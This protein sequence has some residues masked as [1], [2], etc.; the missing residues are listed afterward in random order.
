MKIG[1]IIPS[2]GG[3]EDFGPL[4]DSIDKNLKYLKKEIRYLQ[5]F[6]IF[7]LNG[8]YQ[9]PKKYLQMIG[10]KGFKIKT[11]IS[12]KPGKINAIKEAAKGNTADYLFLLDDDIVFNESLFY[13]A[14]LEFKKHPNLKLVSTQPKTVD[15]W[16]TNPFRKFIYDIIN[17]RSL[18]S[19][20]KGKDPF[21]FGRFIVL[22]GCRYPVPSDIIVDDIYLSLIY[23]GKYKIMTDFVYTRGVDSFLKH[24]KRVILLET[25]R[26]QVR[27][28]DMQKY[29]KVTNKMMRKIDY[30][31][32]KN[33]PIYYR[34]CFFLYNRLRYLTNNIIANIF[35]HKTTSWS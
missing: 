26:K 12:E 16:G 22:K 13:K 30:R 28:I 14:I 18:R 7:A 10:T 21:L 9:K 29:D 34:L 15:Y 6:I 4:L 20:Y 35:T 31:K 19:L 25:G 1:I 11:I 2:S 32:L 33:E 23:F 27:S 17:V 3:G 24:I 8:D 5:Y